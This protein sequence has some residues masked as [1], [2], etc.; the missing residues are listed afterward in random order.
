MPT[1]TTTTKTT[2][3][4]TPAK[5]TPKAPAPLNAAEQ[6]KVNYATAMVTFERRESALAE[7]TNTLSD[8]TSRLAGG[9]ES[10]TAA[11]ID[12]AEREIK[13]WDLL[14]AAATA[15]ATRA[16][17]A[18][19]NTST[20]L[21]D[22][23]APFLAK[24]IGLTPS[25][26]WQQRSN[27]QQ[28]ESVPSAVLVQTKTETD[29]GDGRL[30]GECTLYFSR[31]ALHVLPDAAAVSRDLEGLGVKARV[32]IGWTVKHSDGSTTH[33]FTVKVVEVAPTI[34]VIRAASAVSEN[35]RRLVGYALTDAI[36]P[37]FRLTKE[38]LVELRPSLGSN[39]LMEDSL[40]QAVNVSTGVP[41]VYSDTT[42][43]AGKRTVTVL[44]DAKCRVRHPQ[45]RS[46]FVQGIR[47]ELPNR[48]GL[49][50]GT[51]IPGA[52]RVSAVRL[53]GPLHTADDL[54]SVDA[55]VLVSYVST[56]PDG[57]EAPAYVPAPRAAVPRP[58]DDD[59]LEPG[60]EDLIGYSPRVGSARDLDAHGDAVGTHPGV[61]A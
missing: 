27:E 55:Q 32:S 40:L 47:S 5:A 58:T 12:E 21:A 10:V 17:R 26:T 37:A 16:A 44:V 18:V 48:L 1:K 23:V 42:D 31:T 57:Q 15:D 11:Q 50:V 2:T 51:M 54:S 20:A 60:D 24:I 33:A 29:Q 19:V 28:P 3:K 53:A 39:G 61:G 9:D 52:G 30:S 45:T 13:R 25:T 8:L 4:A 38:S 7:C 34:P 22:A 35:S 6:S 46:R 36:E 43:E 14:V 56:L 59:H 41:S 49:I